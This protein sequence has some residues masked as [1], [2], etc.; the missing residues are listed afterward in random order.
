MVDNANYK[1][2]IGNICLHQDLIVGRH[3]LRRNLRDILDSHER[4]FQHLHDGSHE[5]M[6]AN[7]KRISGWDF[8]T[9]EML[10]DLTQGEK[11]VLQIDSLQLRH[12]QSKNK[13]QTRSKYQTNGHDGLSWL[14]DPNTLRL[15]C[16]VGINVLDT[17]TTRIQKDMDT[18]EATIVEDPSGDHFST[19]IIQLKKPL[20]VELDKFFVATE[21][22]TNGKR[23][24]RRTITMKY[25]LE[26]NIRCLDSDDTIELLHQLEGKDP[27]HYYATPP[28]EG[29]LKATWDNLP[30]CPPEGHLLGLRRSK[31]HKVLDLDYKLEISMG[32][33][34][35]R[36]SP[37]QRYNQKLIERQ[38]ARQQLPTPSASDDLEKQLKKSIISY[39]FQDSNL[40]TRTT[41]VEGFFCP[42]CR[43]GREHPSFERLRLHL[44]TYHDHFKFDQEDLKTSSGEGSSTPRRVLWISLAD[45]E[46]NK[47]KPVEDGPEQIYMNWVAPSRPFDINAFVRGQSNW[48][49]HGKRIGTRKGKARDKDRDYMIVAAP[50]PIRKRPAPEEVKDLP[51]HRPTKRP[52]PI[53]PGV[54]F[55][56]TASKQALKP[57]EFVAESDEYVDE[58]WLAQN[59]TF[60]LLELGITGA[61]QDFTNAF[62]KHLAREQSDSSILTKE[63]L[64]RFGRIHHEQLQDIEWQRHFRAKLNQIREAGI[65]GDETVS[66]CVRQLQAASGSDVRMTDVE[67]ESTAEADNE[68]EGSKDDG[69]G[70]ANGGGGFMQ[71]SR[72]KWTGDKISSR[73]QR[74]SSKGKARMVDDDTANDMQHLNGDCVNGGEASYTRLANVCTCGSPATHARGSIACASRVGCPTNPTKRSRTNAS[75][76]CTRRDFH[77]SCVGLERRAHGWRCAECSA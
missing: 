57:G 53:I 5:D 71:R 21:T 49:R 52:I 68:E 4:Q 14:P 62:N 34:R 60:G 31:G 50:K 26:I 48:G 40:S 24:W 3:F 47:Q 38:K 46:T 42:F 45:E 7:E 29:L 20:L 17:R 65:I 6:I 76:Q 16:R 43:N 54:V 28:N 75:Q 67:N 51:D 15:P 9:R 64:V 61:A 70:R 10:E 63:A 32:W 25:A 74:L 2:L 56:H 44:M 73:E 23:T 35:K 37:L 30:E 66:Y 69:D 55:Y 33:A 27:M 12:P 59:Q 19:Y 77:L 11:P 36:E 22:G 41:S 72:K 58:S 13:I 39:N 8:P 1:K 18:V